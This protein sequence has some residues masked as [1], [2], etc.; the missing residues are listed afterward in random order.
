MGVGFE[1]RSEV[2]GRGLGMRLVDIVGPGV[3]LDLRLEVGGGGLGL[4]LV[5]VV[6]PEVL[7]RNIDTSPSNSNAEK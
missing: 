7:F 3:G 4:R 2:G 6:G 5:D 1:F